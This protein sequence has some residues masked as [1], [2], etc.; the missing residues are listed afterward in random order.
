MLEII[1]NELVIMCTHEYSTGK[2]GRDTDGMRRLRKQDLSN[3]V[4]VVQKTMRIQTGDRALLTKQQQ[5][6]GLEW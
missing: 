4:A 2:P 3:S 6:S 1:P 5:E